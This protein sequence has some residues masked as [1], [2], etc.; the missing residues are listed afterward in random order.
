MTKYKCCQYVESDA[1]ELK[2][3]GLQTKNHRPNIVHQLFLSEQRRGFTFYI[4]KKGKRRVFCNMQFLYETHISVTKNNTSLEHSYALSF[5]H[6]FYGC[7][8]YNQSY[9]DRDTETLKCL[10]F[11]FL[12]QKK[13]KN[14]ML[15]LV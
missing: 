8:Y 12:M 14:E 7:F 5:M 10:L 2:I 13:K 4:V 3:S 6:S 15:V 11:G 9:L 1:R